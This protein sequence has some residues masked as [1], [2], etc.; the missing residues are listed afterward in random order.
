MKE[1]W[2]LFGVSKEQWE[3]HWLKRDEESVEF[4]G[5]Y[6]IGWRTNAIKL[7]TGARTLYTAA[8]IAREQRLLMI[9]AEVK[10]GKTNDSR[11]MT[12]E[13]E[14]LLMKDGQLGI[15]YFLLSRAMENILKAILV[16]RNPGG[17]Y[18]KKGKKVTLGDTHGHSLPMLIKDAGV[19]LSEEQY[20]RI[21]LLDSAAI[22]F[23]YPGFLKA[24]QHTAKRKI[25]ESSD[26]NTDMNSF[27]KYVEIF[28]Y[29]CKIVKALVDKRHQEEDAAAAKA[30]TINVT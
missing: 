24:A 26:F 2:Q 29:L 28:S 8:K 14:D 4:N 25:E 9:V 7:Y 20:M 23:I 27:E 3:Q 17:Y 19:Q 18:D 21:K 5:R 12:V 22:S 16:E 30:V 10:S 15:A 13:E 1:L 6:T 11:P